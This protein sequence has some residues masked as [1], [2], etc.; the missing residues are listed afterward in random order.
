[1]Y[2]SFSALPLTTSGPVPLHWTVSPPTPI[3]RLIRSFSSAD[4]IRPIQLSTFCTGFGVGVGSPA[5]QLSGSWKTT[6][7]PRSGL[8]PNHG[9]SLS[10]RTRSPC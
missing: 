9:V 2:G 7:S 4:G 10:T 6:T 1:M 5:S 8:E 3:T